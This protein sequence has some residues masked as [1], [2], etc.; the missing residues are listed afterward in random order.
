LSIYGTQL[1]AIT[2]IAI[3]A[4]VFATDWVPLLANVCIVLVAPIVVFLYLPF[5]RRLN[6]TTAYEYLERR[7]N[8]AVRLLGSLLFV[9]FQLGRMGVV[10]F[11]PAL[12]LAATTGMNVYLCIALM[13]VLCTFYTVLGGI[14]A[15]I[16]TDVLQVFVLLG[17]ALVALF[18]I[19]GNVDGGFAGIFQS[20]AAEGKLRTF[21]WTWDYTV[22]AVWVVL[23]GNLF[24][25]LMSYTTDQAVIQRYLTTRDE[26]AAARSIW[27]NAVL[28][29]PGSLVF[30]TLGTALYVFYK[31]HPA[32]LEPRLQTDATLPLFIAEKLPA[33]VAGLVIAGV[34][35]ASMSSLDSS[36][37]SVATA[38]VTDFY[39]RFK[40]AAEDGACLRLARWLTLALG[41][42]GTGTALLLAT[43]DIKSLWF[44]YTKILGLVGGGLTGVFMLGIFTRRATGAG[45]FAGVVAGTALGL[46]AWLR[47]PVHF[48]LY[49][50]I[51]A[52]VSFAVG[53]VASLVLPREGR[54]MEGLTLFTLRAKQ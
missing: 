14:E 46:Y 20:A 25:N 21:N 43:Y 8:L 4:T 38:L 22:M 24:G 42:L 16:W 37:N 40:P 41:A 30:F 51:G 53:Y 50:A 35:A 36:M 34:F 12:A 48:Y 52:A 27:A 26:R 3:P 32:L 33:G 6:V 49:A 23:I 39:R 19:A 17:G 11:L 28:V 29:I 31:A 13:G 44:A 15:V 1:S 45:A 54:S 10:L 18:V 2:F 47:T 5:Y 9:L 7:F